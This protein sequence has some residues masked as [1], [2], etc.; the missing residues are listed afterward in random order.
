LYLLDT[1]ICIDFALGRSEALR[2]RMRQSYAKG[3]AIST[4]TLAELR[5]GPRHP[6][7]APEDARRL[8]VLVG[9]LTV[10]AFD[11]AAATAYGEIARSVGV[12]RKS[13]DR[14][15]AAHARALDLT[16]VTRNEA[17]FADV[18]RLRVENWT[19]PL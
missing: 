14:L 17:D 16:L 4:I 5:V 8:D 1:N 13:F 2:E 18:A 6:G 15:I 7:A 11:D 10:H 12:K 19:L 3:L 9:L